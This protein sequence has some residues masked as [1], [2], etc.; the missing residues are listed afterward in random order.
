MLYRPKILKRLTE[1]SSSTQ[2]EDYVD[3][4]STESSE[5]LIA[6][7]NELIEIVMLCSKC[8][9]QF[10][11]NLLNLLCDMEFQQNKWIP[12]IEI[13]FGAP[14]MIADAYPQ[15]SFGTVLSAVGL[16]TKSLNLV[17]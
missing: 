9:L 4:S 16:I 8:L 1:A 6:V 13:Q 11:P 3:H 15:L 7:M 12:F 14:K 17:S 2:L 5:D 10:S